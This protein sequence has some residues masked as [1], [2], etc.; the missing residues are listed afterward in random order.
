MDCFV[1]SSDTFIDYVYTCIIIIIIMSG[2]S[3]VWWMW[4]KGVEKEFEYGFEL[5]LNHQRD[6]ES[7]RAWEGDEF[8]CTHNKMGSGKAEKF[9][10]QSAQNSQTNTNKHTH[11]QS[12]K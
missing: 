1:P 7:E 9:C 12:I 3:I 2:S 6:I 11:T 4:L 5:K 8:L 10:Y